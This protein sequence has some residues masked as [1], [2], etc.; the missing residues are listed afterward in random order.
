MKTNNLQ[1]TSEWLNQRLGKFTSSEVY[2]IIGTGKGSNFSQTGE[3]Y[4]LQ[5]VGEFLTKEQNQVET[6][7]M[8][9]GKEQEPLAKHFYQKISG[10]KVSDVGFIESED[11]ERFGGSPDGLIEG[12]I[13]EIKCPFETSN[14]ID[15]VLSLK[16]GNFKK[17]YPSY[18]WQ[19]QAN[20]MLTNTNTCDFVVFDPRID[21]DLGMFIHKIDIDLNDCE[22]LIERLGMANAKYYQ[23]LNLLIQ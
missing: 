16:L 22:L 15:L 10:K 20:M 11:I 9:W 23:T 19:V 2:K 1:N 13:I 3:T 6:I 8:K 4:I 18:Y 14:F 21:S 17:D 5:K 7:A 12:G